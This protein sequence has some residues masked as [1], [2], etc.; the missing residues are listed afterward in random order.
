MQQQ[1]QQGQYSTSQGL[2]Q[3]Q[4]PLNQAPQAQPPVFSSPP[5]QPPQQPQVPSYDE[6]APPG[7]HP[8]AQY[9]LPQQPKY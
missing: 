9:E 7:P 5:P 8:R 6:I 3:H 2:Q 1:Q 4:H